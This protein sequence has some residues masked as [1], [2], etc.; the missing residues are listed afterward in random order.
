[1]VKTVDEARLKRI[2]KSASRQKMIWEL[3]CF[4][5]P[6]YVEEKKQKALLSFGIFVDRPTFAFYFKHTYN[7][8]R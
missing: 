5:A 4:Y 2:E 7:K 1:M 3:D 6:A 8:A